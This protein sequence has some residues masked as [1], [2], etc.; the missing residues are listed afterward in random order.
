VAA[1]KRRAEP[2]DDA[3]AR[4][5]WQRHDLIRSQGALRARV[6]APPA[7]LAEVVR[8]GLR[9][10]LA[11]LRSGSAVLYPTLGLAFA[12]GIPDDSRATVA[13]VEGARGALARLGGSLVLCSAPPEVR[14][15]A[16]AWGAPPASIAL[17]RRVKDELDPDHRLAPGRFV[18]GI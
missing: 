17:M 18:G 3:S 2:L 9:P 8:S 4:A 16:G 14:G 11:T 1:L 7:A 6:G 12:S 13:A 15:P 5:F 10:L